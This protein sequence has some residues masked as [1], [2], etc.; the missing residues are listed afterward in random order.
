MARVHGRARRIAPAVAAVLGGMVLAGPL[1]AP[2]DPPAD[3]PADATPPAGMPGSFAA[4]VKQVRP[5]V[6]NISTTEMAPAANPNL[7]PQLPPGLQRFFNLPGPEQRRPQR[8]MA[9]GS[10]F[11]ID[12]SGIVVTNDHVIRNGT[13][14]AVTL[15]DGT[16]LP[17]KVLGADPLTDL[18][19]LKVDSDH[20]LP[21]VEFGD[22]SKLEVGDWVVSVGN[23]FG[24]GGTVTAG[25]L[26]ARGRD[27]QAGPYDDFLQISA[28]INLGS[29]GGPTFDERGRVVGINTAILSPSGGN[30]GIGFA[31]PSELAKPVIEQLRKTGKVV[32]GWLGVAVQ[33]I[34]PA[35]EQ[36]L[37]L[38]STKGALIASV[39]KDSPAAKAGLKPGDVITA[40][41][42]R[43]IRQT[44]DLTWAVAL[45]PPGKEVPVTVDRDGKNVTV[46]V[47]VGRLAA[48]QEEAAE[49]AGKLPQLGLGL[50]PLSPA[51]RNQYGITPDTQGVL[52]TEVEAGSP[53]DEAGL[54]PGDVI[55]QVDRTNV[56]S[57]QEA[58]AA[59]HNALKNGKKAIALNI[60]RGGQE[61]FVVIGLGGAGQP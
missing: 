15:Q 25:I 1:P 6:V 22:S 36:A 49:A 11:I 34:R 20:P 21:H 56:F 61:A 26:S 39:A 24:L 54:Q 8:M 16:T 17:A 60:N 18:A 13:E 59:V 2:A 28:P 46:K 10:G 57:P 35:M 40:F 7:L 47:T 27:I 53:A 4:L 32:R 19:V 58:I 42:D 23:P 5:A 37:G 50:R 51:I 45:T 52:V 3:L 29:S 33:P 44:H 30:I 9:L 14:I 48:H 55:T 41:G 43:P 12:P 38:G 31:I